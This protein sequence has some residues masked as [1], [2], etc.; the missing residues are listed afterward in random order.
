MVDYIDGAIRSAAW[1]VVAGMG[2]FFVLSLLMEWVGGMLRRRAT[3]IFGKAY[4]FLLMPGTMCRDAAHALGRLATGVKVTRHSLAGV[5]GVEGEVEPTHAEM[6]VG[7]FKSLIQD[8]VIATA[9]IVLGSLI[10]VVVTL[11]AG[12]KAM[13]PDASGV[14][15]DGKM[16]GVCAY[17]GALAAAMPGMLAS[18]A[19][20]W[21]WTSPFSLLSLYLFFCLATE[22]RLSGKELKGCLRGIILF[23]VVLVVLNCIPGLGKLLTMGAVKLVPY[24]FKLHAILLF[25]VVLDL[26]F[27]ILLGFLAKLLGRKPKPEVQAK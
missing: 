15:V 7:T 26:V 5:P 20:V 10:L 17:Y 22:M 21:K 18:M 2:S 6:R 25:A 4:D 9:P 12:G 19:S 23:A 27:A 1:Q 11:V 3:S 14:V 16:P 13:L 8:L 24:V